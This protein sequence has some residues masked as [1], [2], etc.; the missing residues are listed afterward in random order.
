MHVLFAFTEHPEVATAPDW[1]QQ[2]WLY[3]QGELQSYYESWELL[4]VEEYIF[5]CNSSGTA[6]QHAATILV[7]RKSVQA[8]PVV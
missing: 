2:E 8:A 1:G 3:R 5:D 7:A 4:Y 6:H